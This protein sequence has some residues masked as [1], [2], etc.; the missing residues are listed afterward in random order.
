M[1]CCPEPSHQH[2]AEKEVQNVIHITKT[3]HTISFQFN[4]SL[5]T[6]ELELGGPEPE[7]EGGRGGIPGCLAGLRGGGVVVSQHALQ[8]SRPTPRGEVE[9]SGLGGGVSPAPHPGGKLRGLQAQTWGLSQHALKQTP[10]PSRRLLLR[11]VRILLECILI[12]A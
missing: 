9:G 12:L 6:Q 10:P 4:N 3:I 11:E 2:I 1:C 5:F 7:A 8:V